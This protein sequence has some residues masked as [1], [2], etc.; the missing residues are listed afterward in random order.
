M[1]ENPQRKAEP[2]SQNSI[3]FPADLFSFVWTIPSYI[4][5]HGH[6]LSLVTYLNDKICY[7][8]LNIIN[9]Y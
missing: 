4:F 9:A 3:A 2:L 7:T 6:G 1:D 8:L 5:P